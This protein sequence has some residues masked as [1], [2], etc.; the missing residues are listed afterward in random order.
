MAIAP[1]IVHVM[2]DISLYTGV[3]AD[4]GLTNDA[5]PTVRVSVAGASAGDKLQLYANGVALGAPVTL[6]AEQVAA[7]RLDLA[8]PRLSDGEVALTAALTGS[9]GSQASSTAYDVR[10]DTIGLDN[11]DV[12]AVY[13]DDGLT[14]K[15]AVT[16]DRTLVAETRLVTDGPYAVAV[17][18]QVRFIIDGAYWGE[19]II[20]TQENI[21]SGTLRVVAP[22]L[23]YG[24][25]WF[26]FEPIDAAG[27]GA[28]SA[29]Y[30]PFTISDRLA[31]EIVAVT[32]DTAP[33]TGNV[34]DGGFTNDTTLDVRVSLAD[35]LAKAGDHLI[36]T[37][38]GVTTDIVLTA[39]DVSA[40][41]AEAR[42]GVLSQSSTGRE[43]W[44]SLDARVRAADG[45]TTP[46]DSHRIRLATEEPDAPA[47]TAVS[48]DLGAQT[49][50]LANGATTDDATPTFTL[51]V[52]TDPGAYWQ[53]PPPPPSGSPGH[54]SP[55]PHISATY[56]APVTL[57]ANGQA[58]GSATVAGPELNITSSTLQP[59]TYT[60]TAQAVDKAGN[61][62][63]LS[64]PFSLTIGAGGDTSPPGGSGQV[65]TS[66]GPGSTIVASAG[67]DT[68]VASQGADLLTGG[69]G[70]DAFVYRGL[71]WSAGRIT[72]FVVGSDRLDLSGIFQASG[73]TGA[74]P[75]A[76][77]RMRLDGDG[78]GG[79][80]VVFDRDAPNSGEWPF[81]ITTLQGV[82]PAG[83]TWAKLAGTG[84]A[85]NPPS[86]GGED[87]GG[88]G[89]G[90]EVI[91]SPEP[92]S[93]V[94]G[95]AGADTIIASQGADVLTGAGGADVFTFQTLP[96]S[97]GRITDFTVGADRLDLSSIFQSSGYTGSDPIADGRV[98]LQSDGSG[99]T[100]V[101]FDR[102]APNEGDWPFHITTLQGVDPA[103]LTW[104]ALSGGGGP[105]PAAVDG[106]VLTSGREGD[107]LTGGAGD[108]TLNAG[109]GPDRLIGGGGADHFVYGKL[110][111]NAGHVTDF[112]PGEDVLDLR[113]LS[114]AYPG[115]QVE[116][117]SD[118]GGGTEVYFETDGP[119]GEWPFKIVTLDG[120]APAQIGLGDWLVQ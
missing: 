9:D 28:N 102:D 49:G 57:F 100:K 71:P 34:P 69:A 64:A 33:Q 41:Y 10:I 89:A 17:G 45:S 73:Y 105:P 4:G 104:A 32:D 107:T 83:L 16:N 68:L 113:G 55:P 93:T 82:G 96:W 53:P 101:F 92:G 95:G 8:T 84:G 5:L 46:V 52:D 11:R 80:K 56:G 2:D 66:P 103:G 15:H 23:G 24:A 98:T 22:E 65:Y 117:R 108:D 94:T 99:G 76:D 21:E 110:P 20:L 72:D 85:A 18:D 90:G 25:H 114:Q 42:T 62:S 91:M 75:I 63:D 116:F 87:D 120:V 115:G 59:G 39:A 1:S 111:W 19:P 86:G 31:P 27:N 13:S 58:V 51:K 60:F 3:I 14:P 67:D 40:G 74:D 44:L 81:H 6:T 78:D 54:P 35:T 7:G 79:T 109:Q 47:I 118:G 106:E 26:R 48:D 50:A 36:L 37:A 88:N 38:R 112:T 61:L 30:W 97:A 119:G 43:D 29:N 77:G 12:T 70:D